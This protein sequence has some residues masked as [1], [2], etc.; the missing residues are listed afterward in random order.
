MLLLLYFL[1][2]LEGND[3][4]SLGFIDILLL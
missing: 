2:L 3:N 1:L 4:G